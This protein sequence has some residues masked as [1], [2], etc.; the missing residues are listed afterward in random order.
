MKRKYIYIVG[1]LL[2]FIGMIGCEDM[3]DNYKQYL[4]EY[5]L[6]QCGVILD[7]NGWHWPGITRK[8]K[9]QNIF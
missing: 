1:C 6:R 7:S 3:D 8:I 2:S 9:S 4:E 5:K